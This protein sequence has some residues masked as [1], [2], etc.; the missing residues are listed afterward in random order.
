MTDDIATPSP[1]KPKPAKGKGGRPKS[2]NPR[3]TFIQ[4][5]L[6]PE[7]KDRLHDIAGPKGAA[8]LMRSLAL[9]KSPK[10]PRP[11]PELNREAWVE[12][13]RL[14]SN[15]NQLAYHANST[16]ELKPDLH[17]ALLDTRSQ[18]ALVRALL[19]GRDPLKD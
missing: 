18:L 9:G 10:I 19:M 6:T 2:K 4:V 5:R 16:G 3:T 12:L 13:S 17:D 15:L 7:E 1:E 8:E 11:V 14:A